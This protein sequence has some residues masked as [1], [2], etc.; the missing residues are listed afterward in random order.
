MSSAKSGAELAPG[1]AGTS[2]GRAGHMAPPGLSGEY[3]TVG[4]SDRCQL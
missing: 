1:S 2:S 4:I 3:D